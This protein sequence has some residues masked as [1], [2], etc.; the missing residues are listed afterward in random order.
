MLRGYFNRPSLRKAAMYL[1]L[2]CQGSTLRDPD[3]RSFSLLNEEA[4]RIRFVKSAQK[5]R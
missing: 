5:A 1:K 4:P 3:A 2:R